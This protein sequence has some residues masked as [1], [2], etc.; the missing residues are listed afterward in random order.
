MPSV[1]TLGYAI[2]GN[3]VGT[4]DSAGVGLRTTY[5]PA[6]VGLRTTYNPAGVGL[7]IRPCGLDKLIVKSRIK[8]NE[9]FSEFCP[10]WS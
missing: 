8:L 7:L 2:P 3:P 4:L 5:N 6:G 9:T 10:L 1:H